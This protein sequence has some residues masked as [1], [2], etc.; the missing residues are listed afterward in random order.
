MFGPP[1]ALVGAAAGHFFIDRKGE[2]PKKQKERVM[3]LTAGALYQMAMAGKKYSHTAD[4]ALRMI[5]DHANIALGKPLS[6]YDLPYL[7]DQSAHIPQCVA[8]LA[9][10]TR[11]YPELAYLASTWLWR[12]AVCEGAPAPA[13]LALIES[14]SRSAGLTH[15]QTMQAAF[16]YSRGAAAN[17][18]GGRKAA[19]STLGVAYNADKDQIKQA[20][21]ALSLKYHPDK[22]ANLD[23][24]IHQLTA[25][26][27]AEIKDAYETLNGSGPLTGDWFAHAPNAP[28]IIPVTPHAVVICFICKHPQQLPDSPEQAHCR[29]CQALL[30]FERPLAEHLIA[31]E[32]R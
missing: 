30:T 4:Q 28:Q 1:G 17:T 3:A 21:R 19:S 29:H 13:A 14:F 11:Q 9:Q 26:K 22:H 24:D 15:E 25:D 32:H 5:L 2:A 27:F 23:P 18:D 20:F 6:V 12:I 16:I 7:I 10:G 31:Q 8:K